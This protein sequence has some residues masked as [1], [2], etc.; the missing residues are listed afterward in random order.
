MGLLYTKVYQVIINLKYMNPKK[1]NTTTRKH[2]ILHDEHDNNKVALIN[3]H[4]ASTDMII[5]LVY[6]VHYIAV[7]L[8]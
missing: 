4:Q 6:H 5:I 2:H 3:S 8:T 1:M 7:H